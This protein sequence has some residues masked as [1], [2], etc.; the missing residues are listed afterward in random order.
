MYKVNYVVAG[1]IKESLP[2]TYPKPLALYLAKQKNSNTAY[3]K[4]CIK[5]I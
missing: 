4:W 2:A 5:P 1:K 3:G